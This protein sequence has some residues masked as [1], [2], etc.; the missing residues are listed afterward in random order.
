MLSTRRKSV[1]GAS[2]ALVAAA[3]LTAACLVA[4]AVEA[5]APAEAQP[6]SG[7]PDNPVRYVMQDS[8]PVSSPELTYKA[9]ARCPN[10]YQAISG[11]FDVHYQKDAPLLVGASRPATPGEANPE[12]AWVVEAVK[13]RE[14]I[15]PSRPFTAYAV[16]VH[17]SLVPRGD[18]L[19]YASSSATIRAR[20]AAVFTPPCRSTHMAIG[21]GFAFVALHHNA[22]D[23]TRNQP[24]PGGQFSSWIVRVNNIGGPQDVRAYSVCIRKDL[25]KDLRFI[26][27]TEKNTGVINSNTERCP[28]NT[29]LLSGGAGTAD[30]YS[31]DIRWSHIRPGGGSEADPPKT[32]SAG[33]VD[34]RS[35]RLTDIPLSAHA[36]CGRLGSESL[37]GGG[38]KLS[39]KNPGWGDGM[40]GG[41]FKK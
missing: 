9:V 17:E 3:M 41:R 38:G 36:L 16:C 13:A 28:Q 33:A 6:R 21:G 26:E 24:N 34:T 31:N 2:T 11:G 30:R 22:L 8:S 15:R 35:I 12:S 10:S 7:G 25:V 27:K 29:Y 14:T 19:Y 4:V 1:W 39:G 18:S 40:G 23:L 32:W 20:S 5:V 37:G